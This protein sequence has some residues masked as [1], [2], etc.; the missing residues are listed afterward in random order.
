M[1]LTLQIRPLKEALQLLSKLTP[2]RPALPI[3]GAVKFSSTSDGITVSA[4]NLVET[5]T[6]NL[7][8]EGTGSFIL[9]LKDLKEYIKNCRDFVQFEDIG[10]RIA[11]V[12]HAGNVPCIKQFKTFPLTDWPELPHPYKGSH[13]TADVLECIQKAIP[14]TAPKSDPRNAMKGILLQPDA[15]I[16]TN[17]KELLKLNCSTGLKQDVILPVTKFMKTRCFA[18]SDAYIHAEDRNL[19]V[20]NDTW[21]YTVKCVDGNYPDYNQVIPRTTANTLQLEPKSTEVLLK[22]IPSLQGDKEHDTVHLYAD[23]NTVKVLP[24]N[25][26]DPGIDAEG[27][28]RSGGDIAVSLNRNLLIRALELGF[29]KFCFQKDG[30]SP[31][32]ARKGSDL[33]VFM[34]LRNGDAD[35]IRK[36]AANTGVKVTM[37]AEKVPQKEEKMPEKNGFKVVGEAEADPFEE[38]L[39]NINETRNKAREVVDMTTALAKDVKA[40]QRAVKAKE[41]D[42]RNTQ[43]L[44]EKLKKVSGF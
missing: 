17:G 7:K 33:Y 12:Y 24:E 42:F 25:L 5:L 14:S 10:D 13:V 11:A 22:G 1:K 6:F 23:G 27:C 38:L 31:V 44:I 32:M 2:N 30:F 8:G 43:D 18:E 3:Q 37:K 19:T 34:P 16:A 4:I 40:V 35:R 21:K 9:N 15:V 41:R 26:E 36:A 28:L 29:T 39:N 20:S